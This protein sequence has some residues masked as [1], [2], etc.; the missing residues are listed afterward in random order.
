MSINLTHF[1][2]FPE[3]DVAS[4]DA[5]NMACTLGREGDSYVVNG[6]KWWSSG[7]LFSLLFKGKSS[8]Q[9]QTK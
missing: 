7:A 6:K 3:P 1:P 5:T 4:S 9:V 8:L 2:L